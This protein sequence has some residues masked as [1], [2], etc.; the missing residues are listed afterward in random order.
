MLYF[1]SG[2]VNEQFTQTA[3]PI[4]E[5]LTG[6]SD[7][8]EAQSLVTI[9][10]D[11]RTSDPRAVGGRAFG[12]LVLTVVTA[13]FFGILSDRAREHERYARDRVSGQLKRYFSPHLV[14]AMLSGGHEVGHGSTRKAVTVIFAD[15][16][17]F[18]A[19]TE[20]VE[21]EEM[22]HMLN[23]YLSAMTD[24][25]FKFDGTLTSTSAMR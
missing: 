14:E 10:S 6:S 24:A 20:R 17:G 1:S 15:L 19:L 9:L 7:P 12:G 21:P 2:A 8:D 5:L 23:E 18:T 3:S 22:S 16:R 11:L 4:F 25:I 13:V